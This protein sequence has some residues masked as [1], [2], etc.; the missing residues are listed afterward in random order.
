MF[1]NDVEAYGRLM[2]FFFLRLKLFIFCSYRIVIYDCIN[3]L[4]RIYRINIMFEDIYIKKK[5]NVR[6]DLESI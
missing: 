5:G 4:T 1:C 6:I 3:I 2:S